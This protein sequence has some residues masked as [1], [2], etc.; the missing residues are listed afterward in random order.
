M[1]QVLGQQYGLIGADVL[2][3]QRTIVHLQERVELMLVHWGGRVSALRRSSG[4][5][6]FLA[7]DKYT[8]GG[9]QQQN[10]SLDRRGIFV[11]H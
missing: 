11:V 4:V 1:N 3:R 7:G 9:H 10:A 8:P 5:M 2:A 6:H